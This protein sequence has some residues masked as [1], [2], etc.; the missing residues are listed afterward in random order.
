MG[1][2][3]AGRHV[4]ECAE[5]DASAGGA[6]NAGQTAMAEATWILPEKPQETN[7]SAP[8][9]GRVLA[10]IDCRINAIS[11]QLDTLAARA[12]HG[13]AAGDRD[14][15]YLLEQFR[16]L[17]FT[18]GGAMSRQIMTA[19]RRVPVGVLQSVLAAFVVLADR[20]CAE[21]GRCGRRDDRVDEIRRQSRSVTQKMTIVID[22]IGSPAA[23][24]A[25]NTCLGHPV[26]YRS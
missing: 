19:T 1:R 16:V 22:A 13:G 18:I 4:V 7:D 3:D 26:E 25:S 2:K 11:G 8:I 24:M 15:D 6:D 17:T 21:A 14:L 12:D 5:L 23:V 10:E 20:L 9:A